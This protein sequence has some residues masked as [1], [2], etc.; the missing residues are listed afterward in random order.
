MRVL[1]A[2]L[3]LAV[4]AN[5]AN[6][7]VVVGEDG[8]FDAKGS[9][10]HM[11]KFYPRELTIHVG[12]SITFWFNDVEPHSVT[13]NGQNEVDVTDTTPGFFG[14]LGPADGVWDGVDYA[15]TGLL[16]QDATS[17]DPTSH[18]LTFATVGTYG[19]YCII[20]PVMRGW[21]YV[22]PAE[23]ALPA[24]SSYTDDDLEAWIAADLEKIPFYQKVWAVEIKTPAGYENDDGSMTYY[25]RDGL[26]EI[27]GTVLYR[28]VPEVIDIHVGDT[29]I[30]VNTD[31]AGHGIALNKTFEPLFSFG[32]TGIEFNPNW[33][34]MTESG[35]DY[36]GGFANGGLLLP[37]QE[38]SLRF[39]K[40]G[41]YPVECQYHA[42][43]GMTAEVR[44]HEIE[45]EDDDEGCEG[46][47]AGNVINI[48]FAGMLNQN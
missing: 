7:D 10:Y 34:E 42:E 2:L 1:L 21:I 47:G 29:V 44:V 26:G 27:G 16:S 9:A 15:S 13:F 33:F 46:H 37:G 43:M 3:S 24:E 22:V 48:N 11:F 6:F 28:F 20:H 17:G 18:T 45:D 30:F 12:D 23:D 4:V 31:I 39:T 36:E 40:A 32:P 19:Y 41:T 38:F 14:P 8:P 35:A 25:V 5:A